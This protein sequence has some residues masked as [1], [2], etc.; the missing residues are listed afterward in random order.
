VHFVG[1]VSLIRHIWIT[2]DGTRVS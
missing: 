1:L 2:S